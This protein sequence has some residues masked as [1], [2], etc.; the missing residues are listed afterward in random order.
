MNTTGIHT[1]PTPASLGL[2]A[3]Q[4]GLVV[5]PTSGR[6]VFWTG[7][8]AIGL[9]HALPAIDDGD[10][11][12]EADLEFDDLGNLVRPLNNGVR[13]EFRRHD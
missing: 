7:R 9:R 10:D 11:L 5:L 6:T 3:D 1:E 2:P 12:R 8:V 13:P 4:R